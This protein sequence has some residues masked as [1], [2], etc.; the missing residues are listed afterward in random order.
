MQQEKEASKLNK[1]NLEHDTFNTTQKSHFI[2]TRRK[3]LY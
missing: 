2:S 3:D 1:K